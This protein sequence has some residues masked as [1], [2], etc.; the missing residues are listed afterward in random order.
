MKV[1]CIG[2]KGEDWSP[3]P[4]D[5]DFVV[6]SRD[7]FLTGI[8]KG[9]PHEFEVYDLEPHR[10]G[11]KDTWISNDNEV[12]RYTRISVA[13][14]RANLAQDNSWAT[15]V[16]PYCFDIFKRLSLEMLDKVDI[17][18][19]R[20]LW[21]QRGMYAIPS[22]ADRYLV[23]QQFYTYYPGT[24]YLV[25][26][27]L[28]I[29]GIEDLIKRCEVAENEHHDVVFEASNVDPASHDP[30]VAL[31][32]ELKQILILQLPYRAVANLRLASH[33]FRQ[34]PQAYFRH[35]IKTE[36]PWFWEIESLQPKQVN[37]HKLWCELSAADGGSLVDEQQRKWIHDAKNPGSGA[38]DRLIGEMSEDERMRYDIQPRSCAGEAYP[39]SKDM[40]RR[41][42]PLRKERS[43]AGRW[44]PKST[45][46]KGLRNRRRI[47]GDVR[48]VLHEINRLEVEA[49]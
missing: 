4:G 16:H 28:Q 47:Y 8:S 18:G 13:K 41:L 39:D 23:N 48:Y 25:A 24:D 34:L 30:F 32:A 31:S 7:C 22:S 33:S 17:D 49:A 3:E 26:N 38:W 2:Y 14:S 9:P 42:A 27:P 5:E 46:L 40:A 19:L 1:Q 43:L 6:H 20:E 29:P 45:E 37:W 11:I 36:M 10:H 35:L 12:V 21:R 15:P 44:W